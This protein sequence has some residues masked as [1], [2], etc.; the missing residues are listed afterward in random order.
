MVTLTV[1]SSAIVKGTSYTFQNWVLGG[2][3]QAAGVTA[4]TFQITADVNAQAIYLVIQRN[5]T[6]QSSP[7]IGVAITGSAGGTT[8]Y[9]TVV[10]DNTLVTLTAPPTFSDAGS[11]Y[12]FKGW[13]GLAAM[14]ETAL[15]QRFHITSDTTL[16]ATYGMIEMAV[17]YPN[18]AGI[19][20]ERG[21]KVSVW[22]NALNLPKGTKVKV[23]LVKGGAQ[24]WTLSEGATKSPLP[25]TV[26]APIAGAEAYPDGNDYKIRVSALDGAVSAE[27]ENPFAIASVE[28]L[29]VTG[30][31]NVQ[32]GTESQYTCTAH[33]S[34]GG[35]LDV[36]SLVKWRCFPTT[37]AK[38]GK[39]GLLV[40]KQVPSEQP[41]ALTATYGKGK[42]P[43]T[44]ALEISLTP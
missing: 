40:T 2:V 22:W 38:M 5:L 35:D 10:P 7:L 13:S 34:F 44:G 27:S 25:W 21:K 42:P 11:S 18:D 4:L 1:P 9:S 31:T 29:Y 15:T 23:Q 14:K 41:C 3:P 8:N 43:L 6:V 12:G 20:L 26:G 32:G 17:I 16:T 33:Y 36:T 37:Y 24:V 19:I 28:S 39:T 30:P